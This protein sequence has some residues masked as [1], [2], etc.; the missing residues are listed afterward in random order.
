MRYRLALFVLG[1]LAC[2]AASASVQIT[3]HDTRYAIVASSEAVE[4]VLD[5]TQGV[6][7]V[8]GQGRARSTVVG[9]RVR[10]AAREA[11]TADARLRLAKVFGGIKLTSYATLADAVATG[12]L[13]EL[14]ADSLCAALFPVVERWDTVSRTLTL[15]SALPLS[16]P[17]SMNELAARMLAF[18]Q[19]LLKPGAPTVHSPKEITL[20]P[21]PPPTQMFDG[22][23]TGVIL[24]CRGLGFTP[25]LLPKL[26]AQDGTELWG[27]AGINGV[28]VK[29]KGLVRYARDL[30]EALSSRRAG[31]LPLLLR[32]IGTAEPLNGNLV[33]RPEDVKL[34]A[35]EKASTTWLATLSVVI[36]ID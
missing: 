14:H 29:E 28:L 34:L 16:G 13:P 21:T 17:G 35:D 12:L 3:V 23:Y 25:T 10:P 31:T 36:L 9:A 19:K 6:I 26:L 8:T 2:L 20:R 11:A 7:F 18:E 33:L 30:R 15:T 1:L 32:P 27:T 4:P 5:W 24:D 22:P